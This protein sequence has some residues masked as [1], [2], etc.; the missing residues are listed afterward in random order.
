MKIISYKRLVLCGA[1]IGSVLLTAA[2][3]AA[4]IIVMQGTKLS[5]ATGVEVSGKKYNVSFVDGT[6][7]SVF[8]SCSND[9]FVF[10][11]SAEAALASQAL[12]DQVF[13]DFGG[14]W[15][16]DSSP[17][18]I[19]GCT[20][21]QVCAA[22]TPY[23]ATATTFSLRSAANGAPS[24]G[25]D[26]INQGFDFPHTYDTVARDAA[27]YARW[28]IVEAEVPEPSS[29]ALMTLAVAGLAFS[30]RRKL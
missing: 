5:G 2:A 20:N 22:Y 7:V 4:P 23:V 24:W 10:K 27:V 6:C 9:S 1:F 21:T 11:T 16:F 30:R 29:V 14:L 26:R 12:L 3:S 28:S 8:G 25:V 15:Q 19:N 17:Q 13:L 18:R